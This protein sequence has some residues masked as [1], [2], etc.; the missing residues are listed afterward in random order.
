MIINGNRPWAAGT[1]LHFAKGEEE[2]N[3][4]SDCFGGFPWRY[5]PGV[6]AQNK[7]NKGT[8]LLVFH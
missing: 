6:I 7:K 2:E 3:K 8:A 5:S 1:G 4:N